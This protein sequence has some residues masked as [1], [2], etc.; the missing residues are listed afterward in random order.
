MRW[1]NP[2]GV[3]A[4]GADRAAGGGVELL[5]ETYFNCSEVVVAAAEG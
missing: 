1:R 5:V 3:G 2:N 4:A